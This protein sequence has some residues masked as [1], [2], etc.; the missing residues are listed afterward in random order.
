MKHK[1]K[2][3][4][5]KI[6]SDGEY[7]DLWSF[8]HFLTGGGIA[9]IFIVSHVPFLL[10]AITLFL[11]LS[12]WEVYEKSKKIRETTS[13]QIIDVIVG[14]LGGAIVYAVMDLEIFNNIILAIIITIITTTLVLWGWLAYKMGSSADF[15]KRF[16]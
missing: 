7:I 10:G 1:S 5:I 13:N 9:G 6:W 15:L 16:K 8:V 4:Y 14:L 2:K 12:F 3:F 11:L